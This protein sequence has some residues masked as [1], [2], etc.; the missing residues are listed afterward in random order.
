MVLI[1]GPARTGIEAIIRFTEVYTH[2][3]L[4]DILTG[5]ITAPITPDITAECMAGCM[6]ATMATTADTII[7]L[8]KTAT[9]TTPV[10]ITEAVVPDLGKALQDDAALKTNLCKPNRKTEIQ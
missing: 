4:S 9:I 10:V 8:M 3:P 7:Q 5:D 6:A 2:I 1:S